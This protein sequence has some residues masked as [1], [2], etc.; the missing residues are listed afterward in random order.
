M[1]AKNL[2]SMLGVFI[3]ISTSLVFIFGF[4][5]TDQLVLKVD[6]NEEF[7]NLLM[8]EDNALVK[9]NNEKLGND[10]GESFINLKV[11]DFKELGSK[12]NVKNMDA[13]ANGVFHTPEGNF[14]FK[15]TGTVEEVIL[16]SGK[17]L[18]NGGFEG[19]IVNKKGED[20]ININLLYNMETEDAYV[21][22]TSG[23][24]GDTAAIPFGNSRINK[25]EM[26]EMYELLTGE[27]VTNNEK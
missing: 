16:K 21:S 7:Y 9:K 1:R 20:I 27:E 4:K 5:E 18:L 25:D 10:L 15:S 14:N 22:I 11:F 26:N 24:E 2:F 19:T 8:D 17:K 13:S 6:A 3:L 12:E 23:Y